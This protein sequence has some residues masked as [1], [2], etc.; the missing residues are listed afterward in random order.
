MRYWLIRPGDLLVFNPSEPHTVSSRCDKDDEVYCLT[1]YLKTVVVGLNDN[2]IEL[3]PL[4]N[5]LCK[6]YI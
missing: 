6:K 4:Q 1:T 5:D 2:R 3:T